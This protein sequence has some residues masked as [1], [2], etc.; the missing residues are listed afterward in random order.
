CDRILDVIQQ[1]ECL[2][3][4]REDNFS[5]IAL[6]ESVIQG[7]GAAFHES[8]HNAISA[9]IKAAIESLTEEYGKKEDEGGIPS[10]QLDALRILAATEGDLYR[11]RWNNSEWGLWN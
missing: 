5:V 7:S 11:R 2:M 3:P 8:S 1:I 6:V 9:A 4:S 10:D